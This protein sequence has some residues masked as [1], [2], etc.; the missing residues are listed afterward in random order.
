M[1]EFRLLAHHRR[2]SSAAVAFYLDKQG[3]EV[4]FIF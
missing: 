2:A 4:R 1:F 3:S